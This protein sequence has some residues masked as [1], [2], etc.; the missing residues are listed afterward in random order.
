MTLTVTAIWCG[1]LFLAGLPLS[2]VVLLAILGIGGA[3]GAYLTFPHVRHRVELFLNPET[4]PNYQLDRSLAA[5]QQ[6]G[7]LGRGAAEGGIKYQIPDVH[8]DFVFAVA[9]EE[10]GA[11]VALAVMG[12]FC[13]IILR[14]ML[15]AGQQE[16]MFCFLAVVG[17]LIQFAMQVII[18]IGV[19][20]GLFPTKG[21]TLP[22]LSY[23]GSSTLA[24]AIAMGAVLALT[25]RQYRRLKS[26]DY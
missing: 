2:G 13:F 15:R 4:A 9:G 11:L 12:L 8:T 22:F 18:N 25:R 23:G 3:A 17:I 5:F 26:Y 7:L 24:L 1:Q 20:L 21:M 14:G 16:D 19:T 6:G 10:F